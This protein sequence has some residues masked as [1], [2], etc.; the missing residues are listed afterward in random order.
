MRDAVA[1]VRARQGPVLVHATVIRPY[2][3]SLSDDEKLYKTAAEREAEAR[4]DP[5]VRMRHFLQDEGLATDEELADILASSRARSERGRRRSA[6]R[7]PKP[8]PETAALYVF[9]PD[10][11]PDVSRRSRPSRSRSGHADTMVAR[12]QRTL[13]DEMAR[14][15][16]I[17]VFGEDVAD[18]SREEAL[19]TV[20]GKGGVFKVTHGLQRA[21][22]QRPRLQLAARRGQ[23]HRPRR[24]HGAARAEAGRRDPVLRLHL[25]RR[26]CRFA[27]RCR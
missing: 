20:A 10:V 11:D 1:H 4:R 18:A 24:R 2:S 6:R 23:H 26:S 12:N 16:R 25:A 3:H 15:P 27:T 19:A 9:S 17:V 7:A 8:D 5:L 21:V 13:R 14:N 22:R